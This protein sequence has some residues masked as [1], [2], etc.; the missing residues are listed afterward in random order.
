M[1]IPAIR[2]ARTL[3]CRALVVDGDPDAVGRAE[4]DVFE[5]VDLKDLEGL[6]SC[7]RS[8]KQQYGLD[9]VFTAGTDFSASVAYLAEQLNL[10]GIPYQTAL[11]AS[12]KARMRRRFTA[13]GVPSPRFVE[14]GEGRLEE[15]ERIGISFPLVV[16]P[17]D[18]MGARGVVRVDS[19]EDLYEKIHDSI[20]YS[21][22][23]TVIVEEFIEGPEFSLDALIYGGRIQVCGFADRHIR[24]PP[25]FVEVGHTIP[26]EAPKEIQEEVLSTFIKGIQ[27]LGID[28]GA[29]K[30]DIFFSRGRG[31][32]GEIAAR[33]SG[34]YM[35]GWT[36]PYSS[37]VNL[38]EGALKI[39]LGEDPGDRTPKLSNTSAERALISIPGT[40]GEIIGMEDA[41][42][43]PEVRDIFLRVREGSPVVFPTN[44]V[45]KC[46]NI[47]TV[48]E[49]VRDA[50]EGAE[51][52][53]STILFRLDP[54]DESTNTF[55]FS[56][57]WNDGR[58]CF[59]MDSILIKSIQQMPWYQ[60]NTDSMR[61]EGDRFCLPGFPI[62]VL[63]FPFSPDIKSWNYLTILQ[64]L[65]RLRSLSGFWADAPWVG[66]L[67]PGGVFWHALYRGGFQ[68]VVWVFDVFSR[69][70]TLEEVKEKVE[71]WSFAVRY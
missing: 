53:V 57:S 29:A 7:A 55:L 51:E 20:R 33:L 27:A 21:R 14:L 61:R 1:Q 70:K 32:V 28:Q 11:D 62:P 25:Y 42:N 52:A 3:G 36:Y 38:T 12:N 68:G 65:E 8:W 35:S 39:A 2:T 17:V 40:V 9:G 44:N 59:P 4:A 64:L 63:P 37:G 60:Q 48:S 24:F 10:P 67:V 5:R 49:S 56:S 43:I 34:G 6:V 45:E 26:T 41:R 18:N 15:L 30:G 16:K 13:A 69:C 54:S 22:T 19:A 31:V 58:S 71:E 66:R 46:G 50:V 47:I 23:R